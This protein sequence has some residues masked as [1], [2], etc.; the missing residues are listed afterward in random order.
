MYKRDLYS[1][2]GIQRAAYSGNGI[3]GAAYSGNGISEG[4]IQRERHTA[5]S[6]TVGQRKEGKVFFVSLR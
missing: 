6:G 4:G 1:E 2:G 5:G 3:S